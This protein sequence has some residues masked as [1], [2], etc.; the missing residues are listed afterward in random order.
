MEAGNDMEVTDE[1]QLR[2]E[3]EQDNSCRM[4]GDQ[5]NK[6]GR[7]GRKDN[8]LRL[9]SDKVSVWN[10]EAAHPHSA[11]PKRSFTKKRL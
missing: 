3:A 9:E 11:L 4:D 5:V 10:Q 8:S 2:F 1:N 7:E 6:Y